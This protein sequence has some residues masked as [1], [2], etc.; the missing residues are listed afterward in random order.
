MVLMKLFAGQR[1][2]NRHMDTGVGRKKRVGCIETITCTQSRIY[3]AIC[4]VGGQ[5]E[6]AV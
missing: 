6:L 5:G 2:E 1:H 3:A 4:R